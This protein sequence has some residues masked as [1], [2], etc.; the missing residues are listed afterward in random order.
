MGQSWLDLLFAH[1]Q[2]EPEVLQR[3]MPPQ[4][5]LDLRDGS[6]WIAVTRFRVEGFHLRGTTAAFV[7]RF[8]EVNVRTYVTVAGKP[9]IRART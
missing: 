5:P 1:W 3:V 4:L 9:G 7:S 2:V 8:P 6:A